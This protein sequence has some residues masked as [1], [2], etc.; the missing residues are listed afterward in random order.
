MKK[1]LSLLLIMCSSLTM[2]GQ[3]HS[4]TD[5]LHYRAELQAT[6]SSGDNTPLWLNANKYGLSSLKTANG[7]LRG[8]VYRP[9]SADNGRKWGVGYGAD[10]AVAAGFT[11]KLV[12]QQ[13]YVEGRWLKGVLTVGAKEYPMELK[14]QELSTGAQT[15]GVNARPIPQVRLALPDYWTIPG[16]KNWLAL[17]GHIAYGKTTD[18]NWQKEF[19]SPQS[20]YTEG[21]LYHSKAGYLKIG[22]GKFTAELGLEM[23]CQ[24]GG[25]AYRFHSDGSFD[26]EVHQQGGLKG[27]LK[28]L[29]PGGSDAVD[30]L[31]TGGAGNSLGSW[32]ARF[33]FDDEEWGF[34]IYA[35]HFF[36]DHSAMFLTE[37]NGYG[38]G[39][40]WNVKKDRRFFLYGLKDIQF[41]FEL[42]LKDARW[43]DNIV[44]E[45]FFSKYQS[46]PIYHDH[47]EVIS[48]HLGGQDNY[49]NH[50]IYTGWQHWGQVIGNP[51]YLSPI[52]NTDQSIY[53]KNN[54]SKAYHIGFSGSPYPR[55][56]YRMLGTY[57]KGY[58]TYDKP[59]YDPRKTVSLLA[60]ACYTFPST[61]V[62]K[63]WSV[64]GAVGADFGELMGDNFGLQM[65][66]AKS[67]LF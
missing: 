53:I 9:L 1:V 24:F 47:D 59:Y 52:Y 46:G 17:K 16:T 49:Y 3:Q 31:Y 50:S 10:V 7:Y 65:T 64:K 27:M 61:S 44:A 66:I 67:G 18:D 40:E 20:R 43:I 36:E 55:F 33:N 37:Y 26:D 54:R 14:N 57:L 21:T 5:S 51:L 4:L 8:A 42:R 39:D 2:S 62:L 11:S 12:V 38:E 6:M 13:A 29:I 22:P 28:A 58:G 23:A 60:E 19:V 30:D 63:G 35:D 41:G 56:H 25:T 48:D 34:S 32:L 45:L 15:L